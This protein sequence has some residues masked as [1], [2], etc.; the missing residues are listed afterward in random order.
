MR[1][2]LAYVGNW[3]GQHQKLI[4]HTQWTIIL[5]YVCLM[6]IPV[7]LPLPDESATLFHHLT[8]FAGFLFWGIWWPFVLISIIFFGR[9]WCGVLCPEGA[10]SEFSNRYGREKTIPKWIRWGGW[11]FVAFGITTL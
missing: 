3:V 8:L 10:L 7:F 6:L 4:R 5:I 9:L 1:Y 11:P 2:N